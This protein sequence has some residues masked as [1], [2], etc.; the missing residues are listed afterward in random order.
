MIEVLKDLPER[1]LG[2]K[3]SG[4]V[5]AKDYTNV[6]VPAIEERLEEYKKVRLLYIFTDEFEGFSGGA[7]WEDAKVGMSHLTA[8]ERVAIVTDADWIENMIRAFGFAMPGEVRVFAGRDL[9]DARQWISE[10][11]S[12]GD[13]AFELLEDRRVLILEPRGELEAVDFERVSAAVD[14]FLEETGGL[15]GV[16]VVAEHFPG[17][18]DFAALAAHARFVR[19]HHRRIRRVALVTGGRFVSALPGIASWFVH[20]EVRAFA[21]DRRD[22]ALLWVGEGDA[23]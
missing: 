23:D 15:N 22:E 12:Q 13:L 14:D 16:M 1:V 6:L 8:F 7:A 17:W 4:Q 18:D 11:P 3:A 9:D 5:T 20:S 19:E 21:V 2:V 10:P